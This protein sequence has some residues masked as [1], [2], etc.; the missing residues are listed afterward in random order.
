MNKSFLIISAIA[1]GSMCISARTIN[2]PQTEGGDNFHSILRAIEL[3]DTTTVVD[4]S[5][6]HIP[7]YWCSIDSIELVGKNTGKIYPAERVVGY[8]FGEKKYMPSTGRYDFSII[9]P[10]TD[11]SDY[12]VDMVEI[13]KDGGKNIIIKGIDLTGKTPAAKYITHINGTYKGDGGFVGISKSA[14]RT[15]PTTWIPVDNGKFTYDMYSDELLAYDIINGLNIFQGSWTMGK[16]FTENATIDIDFTPRDN[17]EMI[18]NLEY[19]DIK[20]DA[21]LGSLT[22]SLNEYLSS[23]GDMFKNA[24]PVLRRDSLEKNR[25][26]YAPEYYAIEDALKAHPE[27]RDSLAAEVNK[28]FDNGMAYTI[29][30]KQ[31]ENDVRKFADED[32]LKLKSDN[33]LKMNN[34]AGLFALYN[35]AYYS[36]DTTPL[37]DTYLMGYQGKFPESEYAFY[38]ERISGS[39][40]ITP[41][42]M[43]NDFSAVDVNGERHTSSELIKGKPVLLDL[44]ASWCGPCRRT[45]KSMIPVYD[46]YNSKGFTIIGVARENGSPEAAIDAISKDGYKWLNLFEIDDINGIWALYRCQNAAGDTFLISP[47]GEIVKRDVS[48]EE[49]REYLKMLYKD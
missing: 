15:T 35:E 29:E 36:D 11:P 16:F 39:N 41:G 24:E 31:S 28:L 21:P 48:A 42:S 44:W 47:E 49:V 5:F 9:F 37:I 23:T 1:I 46:E 34:L 13:H 30:G 38:M 40:E 26:Y 6:I 3:S 19:H 18:G 12:T 33:I 4:Y 27:K 22:A 25:K 8:N 45:S 20:I 10:A 32:F 17:D 14:T 2:M 7:D 43:F